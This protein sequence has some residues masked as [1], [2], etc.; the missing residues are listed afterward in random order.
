[1]FVQL[2]IHEQVSFIKLYLD[3]SSVKGQS[4]KRSTSMWCLDGTRTAQSSCT[5]P[6]ESCSQGHHGHALRSCY[7]KAQK[8]LQPGK[9]RWSEISAEWS[10]ISKLRSKSSLCTMWV[11]SRQCYSLL[12]KTWVAFG[13]VLV[14]TLKT[15]RRT[16]RKFNMSGF[17]AF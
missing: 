9:P 5:L 8:Y 2:G 6:A 10:E 4:W 16:S 7:G 15:Y 13:T 12:G 11:W 14:R 1:M 17:V 3:L